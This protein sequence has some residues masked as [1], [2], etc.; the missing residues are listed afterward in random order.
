[1][2]PAF[3]D[4]AGDSNILFP[5][6]TSGFESYNILDNYVRW[7]FSLVYVAAEDC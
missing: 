3:D 7:G 6:V 5:F 1:M 4:L 2:Y